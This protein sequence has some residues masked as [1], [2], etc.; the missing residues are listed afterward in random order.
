MVTKEELLNVSKI[1]QIFISDEEAKTFT[2]SINDVLKFVDMMNEVALEDEPC[3][4]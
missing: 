3:V 2:K 1:A 4:N